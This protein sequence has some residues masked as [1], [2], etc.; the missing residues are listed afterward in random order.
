VLGSPYRLDA[1]RARTAHYTINANDACPQGPG[2]AADVDWYRSG[3]RTAWKMYGRSAALK[4]ID[5][6]TT[7][8]GDRSPEGFV[9]GRARLA[10]V[11]ARLPRARVMHP[12]G[13]LVLGRTL[14]SVTKVTGYD[15]WVD[16]GFWFDARGVLVALETDAGGC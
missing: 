7:R 13:S 3:V 11:R 10:A 4:L 14:L 2:T 12:T 9:V 1:G 16:Y 8:R 6:A 5:V 15:N